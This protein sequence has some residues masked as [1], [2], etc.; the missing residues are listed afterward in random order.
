MFT[1]S[2]LPILVFTVLCGVLL[3]VGVFVP[4]QRIQAQT[5]SPEVGV[6]TNGAHALELIGK[7]DQ[8]ALAFNGYGYFTSISGI[9]QDQMFTDPVSHSEATAHFTFSSTGTASARSVIETIFV[10]NGTGS[11]TIYYNDTPAASFDDPTTFAKGTPIASSAES[12]QNIINVQA[13]DTAISTTL[14]QLTLTSVIPF[15][16]NGLSYQ[17]GHINMIYQLTYIGEGK[18]TNRILPQSTI[19]LAGYGV[20]GGG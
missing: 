18:R 10:L 2:R 15:T 16:L 14:N 9:P 13:P 20:V 7:I 12:W 19:I 4:F 3:A 11:S 6:A 8:N 17:L 1:R 5:T